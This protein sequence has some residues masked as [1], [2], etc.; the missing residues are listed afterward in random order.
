MLFVS[1]DTWVKIILIM[2]LILIRY[3]MKCQYDA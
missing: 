2:I 3:Y 1:T